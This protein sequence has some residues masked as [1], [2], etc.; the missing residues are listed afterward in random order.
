MW[1]R[2]RDAEEEGNKLQGQWQVAF[3]LSVTYYA[4]IMWFNE[5]IHG[6]WND[7]LR[8]QYPIVG[9]FLSDRGIRPA[10][11]STVG[12][13]WPTVMAISG[14]HT[15]LVLAGLV[16]GNSMKRLRLSVGIIC[17][18][19]IA[20]LA[21]LCLFFFLQ[22]AYDTRSYG[23]YKMA[24]DMLWPHDIPNSGRYFALIGAST[25][26]MWLV[27]AMSLA[28]FDPIEEG[29]ASAVVARYLPRIV[30]FYGLSFVFFQFGCVPLWNGIVRFSS[31]SPSDE[32]EVARLQQAGME[33]LTHMA[34]VTHTLVLML[35]IASCSVANRII[36]NMPC[37]PDQRDQKREAVSNFAMLAA[38]CVAFIGVFAQWVSFALNEKV[39]HV[40]SFAEAF[41]GNEAVQQATSNAWSA[42]HTLVL[43]SYAIWFAGGV[44]FEQAWLGSHSNVASGD[45]RQPQVA[46]S[47]R[48][49]AAIIVLVMLPIA[50]RT[51]VVGA[52]AMIVL[53]WPQRRL[54]KDQMYRPTAE[55]DAYKKV[56]W[57]DF[58]KDCPKTGDTYLVIG[59]GFVGVCLIEK[60]L[61]RG[62]TKIRAFDIVSRNPFAGD[63][64]VTYIQGD[65]TKLDNLVEACKGV[66]TVYSTFAAIRFWERMEF[67]AGL[68]YKVN[69]VGTENVIKACQQCKVKRLIQTSTSNVFAAPSLTKQDMD[70]TSPYVTR[71]ISHNHYSWTK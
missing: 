57:E 1:I 27:T 13:R 39:L 50:W 11:P 71:D 22:T 68:S 48:A 44:L 2:A 12:D 4:A 14:W 9:P 28:G 34:S 21:F 47:A 37:T 70:E 56:R 18:H 29:L 41:V 69:V 53:L 5:G 60:L 33:S 65:V 64:R 30:G 15:A 24:G 23:I 16:L 45:T 63:S 10:D 6:T 52:V 55:P 59:V 19:G 3:Q 49:F 62:E 8:H 7:I 51:G 58:V 66:Q 43:T 42:V 32:A 31:L 40:V 38:L 67:L 46:L 25:M 61:E 35:G 17:G 36:R 26:W 54:P 20:A